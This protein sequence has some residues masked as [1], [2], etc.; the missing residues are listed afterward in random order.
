MLT[1]AMA[2]LTGYSG[3][4]HIKLAA[5]V[6]SC[7]PPPC[8]MMTWSTKANCGAAKLSARNAVGQ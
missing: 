6:E 5:S 1:L 7:I 4:G 2:N 8:C 3:D